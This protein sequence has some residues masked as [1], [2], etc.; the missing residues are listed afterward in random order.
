MPRKPAQN[1]PDG[2][3]STT[4]EGDRGRDR[5]VESMP[6]PLSKPVRSKRNRVR[7]VSG[8]F[9]AIASSAVL[10]VPVII[11]FAVNVTA[12]HVALYGTGATALTV[13]FRAIAGVKP[14]K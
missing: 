8:A 11:G 4:K 6:D 12:Q 13:V 10:M 2:M 1:K 3:K 9:L 5:K 14:S 7:P